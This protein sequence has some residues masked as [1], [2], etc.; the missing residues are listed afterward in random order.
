MLKNKSK[1]GIFALLA[2]LSIGLTSCG[3][4]EARPSDNDEILIDGF[5]EEIINNVISIVYDGLRDSGKTNERI[6]RETLLA[7]A[8]GVFGSVEEIRAAFEAGFESA[9]YK[10]L[11]KNH[12]FYNKNIDESVSEADKAIMQKNRFSHFVNDINVRIQKKIF[13][14]IKSSTYAKDGQFIELKY[15]RSLKTK[16]YE[17]GGD[18]SDTTEWNEVTILP[19]MDHEDIDS[20]IN[21][22]RY[23]DYINRKLI[24]DAF[25]T[26]L[27]EEYV[28]D[29]TYAS[30]GRSAAREV[31]Y[32]AISKNSEALENANYLINEFVNT[33]IKKEGA[34]AEDADLEILA[35]AWR[36]IDYV[37]NAQALIENTEVFEKVKDADGNE[38]ADVY[39]GT[40][41]GDLMARY[42]KIND[43]PNLTDTAVES[44]FTAN[45]SY[46]KEHG[47]EI[48]TRD[49]QK[50]DY[51]TDGWYVRNG[52]LSELPSEIRT[53]LFKIGVANELE[54]QKADPSSDYLVEYNGVHYLTPS[55]KEAGGNSDVV[56]YDNGSQTYF[57]IQVSEA[58]NA[59]KLSK[60]AET[61]NYTGIYNDHDKK[62][63]EVGREISR[64]LTENNS[65]NEKTAQSFYLKAM[66]LQFHDDEVYEYFKTNFPDLFE[67]DKK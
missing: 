29:E 17:I 6:L 18:F 1:N 57:I 31:K 53:R 44:E 7:Y 63:E 45:N 65:T 14:E 41:Y 60:D 46:K 35:S 38:I 64:V 4:I 34:T 49:I 28:Y 30:L 15:A 33:N 47:L 43:D 19:T 51:T 2:L 67:D 26:R 61:T 58:V 23:E 11:V 25:L 21:I 56:W 10:D 42:G 55:I 54:S 13:N 52:G 62:L 66:N 20:L 8:K 32:I 37:G 24:P 5:D 59:T 3:E 9:A 12:S 22:D 50:T 40:A 27:T 39:K 48:K 16:M 36:G